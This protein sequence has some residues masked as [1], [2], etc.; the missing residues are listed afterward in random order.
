MIAEGGV[1]R[2]AGI[3]SA[4]YAGAEKVEAIREEAT[5]KDGT[6]V[7]LS[8]IVAKGAQRAGKLPT[9]LEGYASYGIPETPYYSSRLIAWAERGGVYAICGARGGG[10]KGRAWHEAGRSA[11][12][13][14]AHADLIACA[15]RLIE[16]K[17]TVPAH[18]AVSGTSAGGLLA[19]PV[20]LKRPDLFKVVVPRVAISNAT[21]LAAAR[22]GPNQYAEMGDPTTEAGF[23]ALLAQ[24]GYLMADTA[25]D[26]PDWF[27]TVGLNDRRVEPWMAAKLA[28]KALAR[29]G[30][31]HLVFIRA[32]AEA[33]HGIGS[34][35]DQTIEEWADTFSFLLN[36]FG[37]PDF[38]LP[39]EK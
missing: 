8:I 25:T 39:A 10:D 30:D 29:F 15:E 18:L 16:L 5:S 35:R 32:D 28:A 3:G 31:K 24:D 17:L 11:N 38:Q 4:T 37:D 36:R 9:F 33:G 7:P 23:N 19:P 1:V 6:K 26:S 22:N 21:R 14:N 12:K 34:T 27:I 13:P 2:E 20:A